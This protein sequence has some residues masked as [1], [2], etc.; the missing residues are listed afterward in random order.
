MEI[1][2]FQIARIP[3]LLFGPGRY[4]ELP[5]LLAQSG[6]RALLVRGATSLD[7]S[8]VGELLRAQCREAHIELHELA[9]TG[10]PSPELIDGAVEQYRSAGITVVAAIGGGSVIDAGK[11]MAAMLTTGGPVAAFLEDVGSRA[12]IGTTLPFIALP[13][14]AG[15]GSEATKNAVISKVGPGGF[16]K[17]LRHD[18]YIPRFAIIDPILAFSSPREL[19]ASC[20]MDALSQLIESFL[21]TK[22]NAWT[23][24]LAVEG[25]T[26]IG[27]SLIP[28]TLSEPENIALRSDCAYAAFLSGITL[29]N[30]GLG[31]IHGIAGPLGGLFPVPHGTA[32]GTLLGPALRTTLA[33]LRE[34]GNAGIPAIEK[35]ARAGSILGGCPFDDM[36]ACANL[37]VHTVEEWTRELE[38]PRLGAYGIQEADIEAIVAVSDNKNNPVGLS[39]EDRASILRSRL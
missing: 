37:L 38:I 30:A 26:A 15:T 10:E 13:T 22:A 19:T 28:V 31:V 20:G 8:G 14:T 18:N 9:V 2:P 27:R 16:K 25:I 35:M 12:P 5:G 21:S 39:A 1:T 36:I 3:H 24:M 17:S 34:Q 7:R 32:C 11:A 6:N 23:D 4:R 33:R 29:A